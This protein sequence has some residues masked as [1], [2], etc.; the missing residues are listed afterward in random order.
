MNRFPY[1]EDLD[2]PIELL[3]FI[4]RGEVHSILKIIFIRVDTAG[5]RFRN[6]KMKRTAHGVRR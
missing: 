2:N 4:V 6:C 5:I 1:P 3:S